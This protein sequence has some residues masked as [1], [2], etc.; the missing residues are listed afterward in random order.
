LGVVNPVTLPFQFDFLRMYSYK[1]QK[2]LFAKNPS[3]VRPAA[4]QPDGRNG[5]SGSSSGS[6]KQ[7]LRGLTFVLVKNIFFDHIAV[8]CLT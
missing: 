6:G 5:A 4:D 3:T 1:P 8:I 2:R 7:P